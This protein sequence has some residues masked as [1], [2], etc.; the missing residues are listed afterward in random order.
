MKSIYETRFRE[1]IASNAKYLKFVFNDHFVI[2]LFIAIGYLAY[3]YSQNLAFITTLNPFLI[4]LLIA[5]FFHL[6]IANFNFVTFLKEADQIFLLPVISKLKTVYKTATVYSMILP[7]FV[8]GITVIILFPI[9]HGFDSRFKLIYV[10][11]LFISLLLLQLIKFNL[12][13]IK[14]EGKSS[15]LIQFCSFSFQL[16]FFVLFTFNQLL[17]GLMIT[18]VGWISIK[19]F[20]QIKKAGVFQLSLAIASEKKRQNRINRFYSLFVDL[21]E[22]QITIKRRSYLDF[23]KSKKSFKGNLFLLTFL[24]SGT[25][26]GLFVRLLLINIVLNVMLE[27][28]FLAMILSFVFLYLLLFQLGPIYREITDNFWPRLFPV[29][30]GIWLKIFQNQILKIGIIYVT[31]VSLVMLF[32]SVKNW[33]NALIYLIGGIFLTVLITKKLLLK[34]RLRYKKIEN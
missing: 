21:P 7:V 5:I 23:L 19:I 1:N 25:Y 20:D 28:N 34:N 27:S 9:L 22:T 30:S 11:I 15:K 2:I 3:L 24:R 10:I 6:E 14:I 8:Y 31:I 13:K 26:L 4:R 18:F 33:C 32:G 16:L 29:S 12:F 17:I